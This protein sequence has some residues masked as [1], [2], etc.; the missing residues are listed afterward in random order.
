MREAVLDALQGR[1]KPAGV[2]DCDVNVETLTVTF[3]ANITPPDL[4]RHLIAI[5]SGR[6][7][8]PPRCRVDGLD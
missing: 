3:D 1:G 2:R 5:E 7:A 4:I 6:F 8:A